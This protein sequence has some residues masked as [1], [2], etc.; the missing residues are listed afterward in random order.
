MFLLHQPDAGVDDEK[1][2][3]ATA[4]QTAVREEFARPT[5][6]QQQQRKDDSLDYRALQAVRPGQVYNETITFLKRN[7][8]V[9][10]TVCLLVFCFVS[11]VCFLLLCIFPVLSAIC[12]S[13]YERR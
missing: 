2:T 3:T 1:E 7:C 13:R 5:K 6:K 10:Y 8:L 12:R 11:F 4:Q 9:A